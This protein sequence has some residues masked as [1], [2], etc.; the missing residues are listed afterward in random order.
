LR[1]R[2]LTISAYALIAAARARFRDE[3]PTARI[4][5]R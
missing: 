4:W 3:I 5:G 2:G 1:H